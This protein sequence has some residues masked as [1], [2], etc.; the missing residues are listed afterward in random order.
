MEY[1]Q[2]ADKARDDP[3]GFVN[4]APNDKIM[5]LLHIANEFYRNSGETIL[6]DD[7]YDTIYDLMKTRIPDHDF[8]KKIGSN[9][10]PGKKVKLPFFMGGMNKLYYQNDINKWLSKHNVDEFIISDKLDGNSALLHVNIIEGQKK[11]SLYSRG[12]GS[13]GRDISK[14]IPFIG[15]PDNLPECAIRGEL[16]I[17]RENY[18]LFSDKYKNPRNFAN[19]I[20]VAKKS[21]YVQLLEFVAFDLVQPKICTSESFE[22]MKSLGF[23]TPNVEYLNRNSINEDNLREI[24]KNHR[25]KSLYEIDGV[26][27]TCKGIYDHNGSGNPN[28]SIAFKVNAYGVDTEI[29][30]VVYNITKYGRLVPT[31]VCKSININ[32]SC[33]SNING[34]SAKYIV[35]NKINKGTKIRVILSGEIIPHIVFIDSSMT[36][37]PALPSVKYI[38]DENKTHALIDKSSFEDTV[39]TDKTFIVKRIVSFIKTMKI[40]YLSF[41][42]VMKL[43]ENGYNT[44]NEILTITTEKLL[45]LPGFKATLANKIIASI[46]DKI[47]KPI[48]VSQLMAASLCFGDGFSGARLSSIVNEFPNI[49][50]ENPTLEDIKGIKG[51]STKTASKFIEG[52]GHFKTFLEKHPYL[53]VETNVSG[54]NTIEKNEDHE[55][56]GK[57]IVLTGFRD[58]K[59]EGFLKT[60]E[61]VKIGSGINSKVDILIVK[62]HNTNNKKTELALELGILKYTCLEFSEK[63][64]SDT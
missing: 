48:P 10:E 27:I 38:W 12:R 34:Q 41:G 28:Y 50:D 9:N 31:L 7:E 30:D 58:K 64:L 2:F 18:S 4:S 37:E 8:F 1:M 22:Y 62:D 25:E 35:E 32:G 40:D 36:P 13:E 49:L 44:L 11:M 39:V 5:E 55:L 24:L 15:I 63:Y 17:T 53:K 21:D 46:A 56:C 51:F 42:I 3:I 33:I 54:D 45:E 60:I 47:Y 29:T 26:I 6:S 20:T 57:T 52:F 19:S 59:I 23:K 61:G 14:L 43:V 16:I